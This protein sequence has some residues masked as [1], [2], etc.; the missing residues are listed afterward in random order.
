MDSQAHRLKSADIIWTRS[1]RPTLVFS[2]STNPGIGFVCSPMDRGDELVNE[3]A[4]D[5]LA[6]LARRGS[7]EALDDQLCPADGAQPRVS[8]EGTYARSTAIRV[9]SGFDQETI[10]ETVRVLASKNGCCD[11]EILFNVAEKSRLKSEYWKA[12]AAGAPF[13]P[14]R[15]HPNV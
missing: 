15:R 3:I 7:F 8:C 5:V 4:P 1:R 9:T 6:V 11:C 12:R 13:E 14:G 10:S 2:D